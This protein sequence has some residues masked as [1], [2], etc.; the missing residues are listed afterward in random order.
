MT[1]KAPGMS[2]EV[3]EKLPPADPED[4]LT[5]GEGENENPLSALF[6]DP[7]EFETEITGQEIPA[8]IQHLVNRGYELWQA[9]PRKW[10]GK[11]LPDE[12]T[13][14]RVKRLAKAYAQSLGLVFR[15]K[16]V[17]EKTLVVYR[18]TQQA[19]TES[20][21]SDASANADSN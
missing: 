14:K 7:E 19:Q 5:P 10:W 20:V 8:E 16:T 9:K 4:S 21:A 3:I 1:R 18:V 12:A 17:T 6:T 15:V 13:A 11:Q 2:T